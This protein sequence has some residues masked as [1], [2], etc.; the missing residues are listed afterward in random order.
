[1]FDP[2]SLALPGVVELSP[3][4]PGKPEEELKREL[5]LDRIVKLASNENPLGCS[6]LAQQALNK[7]I[8]LA[9]YPD[10]G[11]YQLK[12]A[13]ADKLGVSTDQLTIGNGSN[14]VLELAVRSFVGQTDRVVISQH[15]FA[16]YYLASKAV[17]ADI[18]IIPA[19]K[20]GHDL[21]SMA[22]IAAAGAKLVFIANPN[23]PTGTYHS[24]ESMKTFL[25][26][27]PESTIVIID[28]AYV[29]YTDANETALDLLGEFPNLIITR[30]FSKVYGLAGLRI[31]YGISSAQIANMLNRVRQP[32][33]A[34]TQAQNAAIAA[35]GDVDFIKQSVELNHRQKKVLYAGFEKL[36]L[37]Y[38]GSQ[39]NFV[40]VEI[41]DEKG[42]YQRMLEQ[43][44]IVRPIA[45]YQMPGWLRFTIGT[46][47]ENQLALAALQKALR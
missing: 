22:S 28:E 26:A 44:V 24:L 41:G 7:S 27:V 46:E 16:V 10:G 12:Q 2:N 34:N 37:S 32:F 20:W 19:L 25:S 15:A 5:K 43:G 38:I 30:T 23:N 9:R 36:G 35:L 33:N 6:P 8:N 14:D 42:V 13:L 21:R 31:G 40:S 39:G 3:Y 29:E 18:H 47:Q 17:G 4:Q 45:N 11:A 1:M